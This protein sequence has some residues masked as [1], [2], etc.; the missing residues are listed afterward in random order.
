MTIKEAFE[1]LSSA[2]AKGMKNPFFVMKRLKE[3]FADV[4]DKVVDAG[5]SVVSVTAELTEGTKIAT[6]TVDGEDTDLYAPTV[7]VVQTVTEGTEIGSVNGIKLYAPSAS[8]GI[9]YTETEQD[10]GLK[11]IDNSPIY[12]KTIDLGVFPNATGEAKNM[13][14]NITNLG[15]LVDIMCVATKSNT[16]ICIPTTNANSSLSLMNINITD[17]KIIIATASA[18]RDYHGYCTLRYTKTAT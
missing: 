4:A 16:R 11:W 13:A 2:C 17:T 18:M 14:H 7:S 9:N 15:T 1:A 3:S 6:V 10:T 8:A 12:Q 5:G